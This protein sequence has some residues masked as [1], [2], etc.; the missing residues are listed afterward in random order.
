VATEVARGKRHCVGLFGRTDIIQINGFFVPI[1]L[2]EDVGVY[3]SSEQYIAGALSLSRS[4]IYL[5]IYQISGYGRS[6]RR[7]GRPSSVQAGRS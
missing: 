5:P 6:A 7:Q 1:L 4:P 3:K 2:S